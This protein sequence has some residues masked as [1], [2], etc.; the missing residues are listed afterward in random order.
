M[1]VSVFEQL[2]ELLTGL[3]AGGGLGLLFDVLQPL[4]RLTGSGLAFLWDA[5]FLFLS[6]GWIFILGQGSGAGMRL[7][8]LLASAGG[9]CFYLWALH[10]M[11]CEDCLSVEHFLQKELN[12]IKIWAKSMKKNE[13]KHG[14]L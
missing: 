11:V 7:F 8:F 6:G 9:F 13:K 2:R 12:K 5:L 14:K 4:R 3:V 1:E 10:P